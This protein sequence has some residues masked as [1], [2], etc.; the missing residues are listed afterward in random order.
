MI[1]AEAMKVV[2]DLNKKLGDG[3]VV[4]A[5]QITSEVIPKFRTGSLTLDY[6]LGGGFA[7]NQWNELIGEAGHGKTLIALKTVAKNQELNPDF[8]TVWVAAES[9]VAEY[10]DMCGVDTSRVIVIETNIMEEAFE[11]VIKFATSRAVDC[12]VI[13][14]LPALI[15]SPEADKTMDE[16]TVGRGAM[17]TNKFFRKVG[18][19]MKRSLI[20]QERPVLGIII[21]QWRSKIGVIHG[22][23]RTTPGGLGKDYAYFTRSEVK[24]SEFLDVGPSGNKTRVGQ[25]VRVRVIKNKTAPP[26][27]AAYFDFYFKDNGDCRA[28]EY[29]FAREIAALCEVKEVVSRKGSWYYFKD[30]KWQ[31][32]ES[33]IASIRE[34]VDLREELEHLALNS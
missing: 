32:M 14:S 1:N 29:D 23:P 6:V 17:I 7:G 5:S 13:D 31:G 11:S 27:G 28:G 10:A 25:R 8:T 18:S 15:P 12:I 30:Y 4:V 3:T 2:Q 22:D 34:E 19:A 33:L 24:R 26:N 16:L 9:W 20:E 21:N